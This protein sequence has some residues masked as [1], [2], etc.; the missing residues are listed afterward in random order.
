VDESLLVAG[1]SW[2]VRVATRPETSWSAP[3][4]RAIPPWSRPSGPRCTTRQVPA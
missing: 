3:R 1:F 2:V 4:G